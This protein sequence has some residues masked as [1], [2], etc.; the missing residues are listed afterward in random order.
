MTVLTILEICNF[1]II[2]VIFLTR[3]V[4][5]EGR[6]ESHTSVNKSTVYKRLNY[7]SFS[8]IRIVRDY[9]F[10]FHL[11]L[12]LIFKSYYD[13]AVIKIC[14]KRMLKTDNNYWQF[15]CSMTSVEDLKWYGCSLICTVASVVFLLVE[16]V[17]YHYKP[18]NYLSGCCTQNDNANCMQIFVIWK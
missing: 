11:I 14:F 9:L 12:Y 10:V 2:L 8:E 18:Y 15:L 13:H 4:A 7:P 3:R 6:G 16:I 5:F 17:V 1:Y